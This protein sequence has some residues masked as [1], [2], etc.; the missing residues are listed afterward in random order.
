MKIE[1]QFLIELPKEKLSP[2]KGKRK[3][4]GNLSLEFNA[5]YLFL[6]FF[7]SFIFL[8]DAKPSFFLEFDGYARS[9]FSLK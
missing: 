8:S 1:K 4:K 6:E 9:L 3:I 5:K 2:Q 7:F